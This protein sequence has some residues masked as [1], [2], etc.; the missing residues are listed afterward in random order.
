MAS[1]S[2]KLPVLMADL[3]NYEIARAFRQP[4]CPLCRVLVVDEERSMQQFWRDSR[5]LPPIRRAFFA[6]AGF[7]PRHSWL[8]HQQVTTAHRGG[9]LAELYSGLVARDLRRID[10]LVNAHGEREG[11]L[12]ERLVEFA[13][14]S[15]CRKC[16]EL[17]AATARRARA[18]WR[19]LREPEMCAAY[20]SSDG[21][22]FRHLGAVLVAG[23]DEDAELALVLLRDW[24]GRLTELHD[25]LQEF[26][27][28]RAYQ[29][30]D[31]P[32]GNEQLAP[33]EVV[34]RYAGDQPEGA[35]GTAPSG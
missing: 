3:S 12:S 1:T 5:L 15:A 27:R 30:K 21:F 32:R 14:R 10:A 2:S 31:E 24:R 18:G 17:E 23:R 19:L 35:Q 13:H 26:D 6:S 29:Y 8:F 7:C 11:L 34:E 22:C 28:K 4:G 16:E 33:T 25:R 9:A 20:R